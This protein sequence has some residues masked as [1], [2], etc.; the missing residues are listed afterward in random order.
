MLLINSVTVVDSSDAF[1]RAFLF[2]API[3][4]AIAVSVK[5]VKNSSLLSKVSIFSASLLNTTW[6]ESIAD[7]N[8]L[9]TVLKSASKA[10]RIISKALG[11]V[12]EA[13]ATL[14]KLA[15]LKPKSGPPN[16]SPFVTS[17]SA[18]I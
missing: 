5:A 16:I 7:G 17:W 6:L 1:P 18:I 14:P 4:A 2:N 3:G 11:S 9:Y 10:P 13:H 15:S 8:I 12:V